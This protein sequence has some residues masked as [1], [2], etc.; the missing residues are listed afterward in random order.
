M[1]DERL[2]QTGKRNFAFYGII[3]VN[4]L[5]RLNMKNLFLI[6]GTMGVG[7]TTTKIDVSEIGS[8][9]AA[10]LIIQSSLRP[11]GDDR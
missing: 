11:T 1:I 9:E 5:L 3:L 7:K 8:E 4:E 2:P 10:N 6:G